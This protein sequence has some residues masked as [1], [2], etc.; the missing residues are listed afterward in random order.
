MKRRFKPT[1]N[2]FMMVLTLI[3]GLYLGNTT[4]L[5]FRFELNG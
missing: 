3:L 5:S 2:K 1:A 4:D